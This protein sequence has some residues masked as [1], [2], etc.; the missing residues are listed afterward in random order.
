MIQVCFK[1]SSRLQVYFKSESSKTR[2]QVSRT[3]L[4]KSETM[5]LE[6]RDWDVE[7]SSLSD[8][9]KNIGLKV[10]TEPEIETECK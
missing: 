8:K 1:T 6:D 3:S 9:T 5:N 4:P 10:E 2:V 7:S